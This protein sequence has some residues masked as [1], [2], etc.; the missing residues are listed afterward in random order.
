MNKSIQDD[1]LRDSLLEA[2]PAEVVLDVPVAGLARAGLR[3]HKINSTV[4][5]AVC[6]LPCFLFFALLSSVFV[7][8]LVITPS[9]LTPLAAPAAQWRLKRDD[10][11]SQG[12]PWTMCKVRA[13]SEARC[14]IYATLHVAKSIVVGD[15]CGMRG[16]TGCNWTGCYTEGATQQMR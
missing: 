1:S 13:L 10:G 6:Y 4:I 15:E 8:E 2:P 16:G 14:C 7:Y 3:V 5:F 9:E 12:H 11:S